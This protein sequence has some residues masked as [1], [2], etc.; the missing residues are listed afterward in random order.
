MLS[1][2]KRLGEILLEKRWVDGRGL[3]SALAHQRT[4]G[5]PLGQ[6][7]LDLRLCTAAQLLEALAHQTGMPSLD[8]DAERLDPVLAA[9]L[10]RRL[11]ER[12]R[13]VPLRLE[14]PRQSVLVVAIA[15]PASP[16]A[17]EAVRT[18]T[19]KSWVVPRLVTDDALSRAIERL[20]A[21]SA[22]DAAGEDAL[23]H[24]LERNTHAHV[25]E[26]GPPR[27]PGPVLV[28]GW[29]EGV[30]EALVGLLEE[31]GHR[32]AL[33]SEAEVLEAR[34]HALVL[35]PL[36]WLEALPRRPRSRLL[37]AGKEPRKDAERARRLGAHGF[38]AAPLDERVLL[39]EVKRLLTATPAALG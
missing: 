32:A 35:T 36:P 26:E 1:M 10:P 23:A 2:R 39:A 13:V 34:A 27:A 12:H 7:L 5:A 8:L 3:H 24:L 30:G 20:Y 14:G 19:N 17:L 15:A 6:V 16:Q 18:V 31:A 11:A 38:V 21:P 22:A 9:H 28:Y 29:R 25:P 33:A 4:Q 37:V